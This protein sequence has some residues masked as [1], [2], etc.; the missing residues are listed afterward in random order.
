[1]PQGQAVNQDYYVEILKQLHETMHRISPELWPSW[2][3]HHDHSPAH[4]MLSIKQFL[5]Q[6]SITEMEHPS[7][8]PFPLTWLLMTAGC[9]GTK[10]SG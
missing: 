7:Y 3:F 1:M 9:K 8:S 6:K 4:K 10:I 2:I 5:A